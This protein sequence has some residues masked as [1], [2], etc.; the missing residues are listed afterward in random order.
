MAAP[1]PIRLHGQVRDINPATGEI[2]RTFDTEAM[3]DG[4]IYTACGDRRASVCPACAETYRADTYQLVRAGLAGGKG[5]PESV[6]SHP[7]VF[8]TFTAPSFGPVHTRRSGPGGQALRC[9]PRRKAARCPHGRMMSCPQ[10]HP[11]TTRAWAGRSARTATTTTPPWSGTPTPPNYGAAPPSPSAAAS[12]GS[13]AHG[14]RVRLSYAKVAEFQARGLVHF[15]AIIR[16]DGTDPADPN[17]VIPP[18]PALDAEQLG[19]VIRDAAA[20]TW[21]ATVAHPARP[22]GWDIAWGAP[23]RHPYCPDHRFRTGHRHGGSL[24]PG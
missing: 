21:F 15:H 19:D 18:P 6:A 8:A 2:V 10:R 9:R 23:A 24:V 20:V 5:V 13:P 7:C 14:A 11:K 1:G 17:H 12:T 3:P 22:G 4:V 16:L